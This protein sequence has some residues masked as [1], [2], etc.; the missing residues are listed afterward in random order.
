MTKVFFTKV[1]SSTDIKRMTKVFFTKVISS[2]DIKRLT[3]V[4]F[5][6]VISSTYIKNGQSFFHQCHMPYSDITYQ[7]F[8]EGNT[9][10][11]AK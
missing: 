4:F 6:K 8:T 7:Y 2:T 10:F 1:I 3:K 5:T 9:K 11:I